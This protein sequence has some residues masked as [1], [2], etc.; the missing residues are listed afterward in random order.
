[1]AAATT[2]LPEE[3]GGIRNWDY[4]YCWLRDAAMTA[5]ALVSLGSVAEADAFLDWLHSIVSSLPGPERLHPVYAINGSS[6][7]PEAVIDTLPGYAARGR[8]ASATWPS[9]RYSLTV[10]RGDGADRRPGHPARASQRRRLA[11]G[12]GH[13]RR[14][15]T[16][17]AEPDHGIWEERLVPRHHVHSKVMCWVT[18]DRAIR[19][20]ERD[21]AAADPSWYGLRDAIAADVLANGWNETIQ[22]FA[23]A[24][25]STDL[26]AAS[27][28]VGL[29]GPARSGRPQIPATVTAVEAGLR[30]GSTVYRYRRDDGAPAGK[31]AS[32][33]ARPGSSR[34]TC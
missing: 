14:G 28:H 30:A 25:E 33:C 23:A 4:R 22:S 7:G 12:P 8:F 34:H 21:G 24:Y 18:V 10:R 9:S 16:A 15:G 19:V 13:V 20:A 17:L 11:A 2:S 27:L 32:T 26:D 6:L 29:F 5:R 3:I 1:M 31:A